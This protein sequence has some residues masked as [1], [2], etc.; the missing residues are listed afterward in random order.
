LLHQQSD[1]SKKLYS[2]VIKED[3]A[4]QLSPTFHSKK[5]FFQINNSQAQALGAV[6]L[7]RNSEFLNLKQKTFREKERERLNNE[8]QNSRGRSVT[9]IN[10][11]FNGDGTSNPMTSSSTNLNINAGVT[12]PATGGS[13]R[14][15]ED[16]K[17]YGNKLYASNSS[18]ISG[19]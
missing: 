19:I 15:I 12:I 5:G 18:V 14:S 8:S 3:P 10:I 2:V 17:I 16:T 4:E 1:E 7:N 11:N 13:P 6:T 9:K